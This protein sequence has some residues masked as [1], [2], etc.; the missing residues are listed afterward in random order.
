MFVNVI[1]FLDEKEIFCVVF[2]YIF[3]NGLLDFVWNLKFEF[4][5][6]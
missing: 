5:I 4:K 1:K 2:L 6:V 3:W